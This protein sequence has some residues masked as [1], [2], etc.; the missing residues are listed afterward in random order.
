MSGNYSSWEADRA[1]GCV[2][3][4]GYT[5]AAC[6]M[7]ICAKGDDPLTPYQD[8]RTLQIAINA[9]S[10]TYGGSFKLNFNGYSLAFPATASLWGSSECA[11]SFEALPNIAS[12]SCSEPFIDGLY[13]VWTVQFLKFSTIPVDNNIYLNDGNPPLSAFSCDAFSVTGV[14][15]AA[16]TL[17]DVIVSDIPEYAVCSNRGVCDFDTGLCSCFPKFEG[18]NCDTYAAGARVVST[19]VQLDVL[20]VQT[21]NKDYTGTVLKLSTTFPGN[22]Y[23]NMIKIED[24]TGSIFSMNGN[25]D[26]V[27]DRGSLVLK[28]D[29]SRGGVSINNGGI[30]VTGGFTIEQGGMKV[31]QGVSVNSGGLH[32]L[33][34]GVVVTG[35]VS[36][37]D[38]GIVITGGITVHTGGMSV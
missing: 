36:V 13:A 17:S 14:V 2:C 8:Y 34:G 32:I 7:K 31:T 6:E 15:N 38:T 11:E 10:G 20:N 12:V 22:E 9:D 29:L 21:T 35:G 30:S 24:A 19:E 3:D 4:A 27:M 18:V 1:S 37:R 28:G 5:G 16:C 23:F 33:G 25:G 26:V